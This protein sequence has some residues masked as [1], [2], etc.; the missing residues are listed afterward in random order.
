[1]GYHDNCKG[2]CSG[3]TNKQSHKQTNS[4]FINIDEMGEEYQKN[5]VKPQ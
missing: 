2:K 3:Q 1:M 5:R 4:Y